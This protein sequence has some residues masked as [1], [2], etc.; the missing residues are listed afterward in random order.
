MNHY[1]D[2][3]NGGI[4]NV[5]RMISEQFVKAGH[6]VHIRF[7]N[8]SIFAHSDNSI[9]KSCK[10]ISAEDIFKEISDTVKLHNIDI[11][12]NRCVI[13]ASPIIKRAIAGTNCRL[14]T[15]YNN[16]PTLSPPSI[17]DV[18]TNSATSTIK[19][20]LILLGYPLFSLRSQKRLKAR[21][22][23]SYH[24]SDKTILLSKN[25]IPEY[26]Q[27]M[28]INSDKLV[29][30]NNP[31]RDTLKVSANWEDCKENNILMV[32]RLDEE[33]KCIIKAIKIWKNIVLYNP[34]WKLQIVG[35]GPDE[36]KIKE[37]VQKLN[38]KNIEFYPAQTPEDFYKKSSIFLMTSRNEGW[39]N[40]LNEAMRLGCIPIVIDTFSAVHDMI[41]NNIDG[42]IIPKLREEDDINNCCNAITTLIKDKDLRIELSTK[43]IEKSNRLSIVSIAEQWL[44]LFQSII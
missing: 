5:T 10:Q 44:D 7:L 11:I 8:T 27:M 37:Y 43:A 42:I 3:R 16:K 15:T 24:S 32:T 22:Q 1:P 31:I 34:N 6:I 41:E 23:N 18:T 13:I 38:I 36:K 9:F 12:V 28:N 33:Q 25:Y 17:K 21:H 26:T 40:T 20:I 30:I 4:E 35:S 39:P 29:Y 2:S 14:I 19:K